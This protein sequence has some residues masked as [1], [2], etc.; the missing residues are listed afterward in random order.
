MEN[1]M[2]SGSIEWFP[3]RKPYTL[4]PQITGLF[5]GVPTKGDYNVLGVLSA[6]FWTREK[7]RREKG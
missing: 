6:H 3:N 1:E 4:K 2:E 7:H 5:C